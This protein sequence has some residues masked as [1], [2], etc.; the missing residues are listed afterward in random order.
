ME[1]LTSSQKVGNAITPLY[2]TVANNVRF[3]SRRTIQFAYDHPYYTGIGVGIAFYFVGP[4]VYSYTLKAIGF[5]AAGV[6]KGT[7]ASGF[8]SFHYQG[9]TGGIF[10]FFQSQGSRAVVSSAVGI[11]RALSGAKRVVEIGKL[12]KDVAITFQM[13]KLVG[14]AFSSTLTNRKGTANAVSKVALNDGDKVGTC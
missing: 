12:A 6:E 1:E 7:L 9:Y 2:H 11:E 14:T 5:S 13:A 10:S 3:A 8:Q 4:V